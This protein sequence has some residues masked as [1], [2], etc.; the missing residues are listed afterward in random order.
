MG[1]LEFQKEVNAS[2]LLEELK[3]RGLI[4]KI[5]ELRTKGDQIFVVTKTDLTSAEEIA[6][7]S[8]IADHQKEAGPEIDIEIVRQKISFGMNLLSEMSV[9]LRK[10][11]LP[12]DQLRVAIDRFSEF[13]RLLYGSHLDFA[14][15]ALLK[16]VVDDI[17]PQE[18]IDVLNKKLQSKIESAAA[19]ALN[20]S[21][22][23][24]G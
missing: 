19:E 8:A 23:K 3:E 15:E 11:G 4:D 2:K 13:Q 18:L 12:Q 24:D 21:V 9:L 10:K 22:V 7:S 17:V 6:L 1:E 20:L 5:Q 16:V 14:K